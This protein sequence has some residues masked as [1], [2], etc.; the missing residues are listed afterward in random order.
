MVT[1]WQK[2]LHTLFATPKRSF[3]KTVR[4]FSPVIRTFAGLQFLRKQFFRT[5]PAESKPSRK[6]PNRN[7]RPELCSWAADHRENIAKARRA[8]RT[9]GSGLE[10]A[11]ASQ[12]EWWVV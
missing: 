4:K 9:P 12:P 10:T 11:N 2:I 8:T 1:K 5:C 3:E 7:R 6:I